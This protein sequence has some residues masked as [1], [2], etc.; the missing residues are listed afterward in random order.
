MAHYDADGAGAI[1]PIR[2]AAIRANPTPIL[3][4]CLLLNLGQ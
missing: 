3:I 4:E 2:I 1:H